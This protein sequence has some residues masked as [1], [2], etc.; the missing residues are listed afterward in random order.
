[1][2]L[3]LNHTAADA[4]LVRQH[5]EW[6]AWENGA[7]AH[8]GC[9]EPSGRVVWRDLAQLDWRDPRNS[10]GL[11][12]WAGTVVDKMVSLGASGFRC[13]AAYQVPAG[14]WRAII[15]SARARHPDLVF[16]A[17]T[18]GCT[19]AQTME[20]ARTGFKWVFNSARWWDFESP[21]LMEQY[22]LIREVCDSIAFPESH[23]TPRLAEE[24]RGWVPRLRQRY[25]FSALF[26]G[27]LMMPMG[28]EFGFRRPLHVVNSRP[29]DWESSVI[30]LSA[31]IRR[32]NEVKR[33]CPVFQE[34]GPMQVLPWENPRLLVFWK[35]TRDGRQEAIV[36]LNKDDGAYQPFGVDRPARLFQGGGPLRCVSPENPLDF[37]PEP[38]EYALRPGEAIVLVT[39]PARI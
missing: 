4:P 23:D 9:D 14:A 15:A 38:F 31:F 21:W 26:S 27:G 24:C 37:V 13:D 16:A 33:A 5:P 8:P 12:A 2:D 28:F 17:E 18:L 19:P 11:Q 34:D 35:S 3:V 36:V 30:D 29:Q 32:V 6:Y 20:T 10:A 25:L 22:G 39:V 1:M 7:P